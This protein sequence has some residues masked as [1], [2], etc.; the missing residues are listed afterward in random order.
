MEKEYAVI[1]ERRVN[2]EEVDAGGTS[3]GKAYI[4]KLT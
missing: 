1:I 3:S 2:L 4:Y